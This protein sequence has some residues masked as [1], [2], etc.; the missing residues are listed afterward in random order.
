MNEHRQADSGLRP[1]A[2]PGSW[3]RE[4]WVVQR[5]RRR[6]WVFPLRREPGLLQC[7][8]PPR[9]APSG[10]GKQSLR[11]SRWGPCGQRPSLQVRSREVLPGHDPGA[12]PVQPIPRPRL[13][14]SPTRAGIFGPPPFSPLGSQPEPRPGGC[15]GRGASRTQARGQGRHHVSGQGWRERSGPGP[16]PRA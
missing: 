10:F 3:M 15:R 9:P 2:A 14:A 6:L 13:C 8:A 12:H 11:L 16:A 5:R 7:A 4:K 1:A